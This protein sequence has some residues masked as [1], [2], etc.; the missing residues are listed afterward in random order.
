MCVRVQTSVAKTT[1][2]GVI[3]RT[4]PRF[5]KFPPPGGARVPLNLASG[6]PVG[7]LTPFDEAA[8]V[9]MRRGIKGTVRHGAR[10]CAQP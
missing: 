4:A 9:A 6:R 7:V 2:I 8:L 3:A 10:A 1:T 5:Q